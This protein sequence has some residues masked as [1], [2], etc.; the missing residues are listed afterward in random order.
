MNEYINKQISS[1][2][3]FFEPLIKP[4]TFMDLQLA[5]FSASFFLTLFKLFFKFFSFSISIYL[6]FLVLF[7]FFLLSLVF[8]I[9]DLINDIFCKFF[10]WFLPFPFYDD[11]P[12]FDDEEVPYKPIPNNWRE[13][14]FIY[15]VYFRLYLI[16][17]N[18]LFI[19]VYLFIILLLLF[20]FNLSVSIFT[21]LF[22]KITRF[23]LFLTDRNWSELR[24]SFSTQFHELE[25]PEVIIKPTYTT[26]MI[27]AIWTARGLADR[28]FF[29][30]WC[31][32]P[33]LNG[34]E[35][36]NTMLFSRV[37]DER[38]IVQFEQTYGYTAYG[39]LNM[40][41]VEERNYIKQLITVIISGAA[42]YYFINHIKILSS[43]YLKLHER[44]YIAYY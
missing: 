40:I 33:P 28:E 32:M 22:L 27:T 35:E 43:I 3:S 31:R 23:T 12:Y 10:K 2:R 30:K 13:Y 44:I 17:F 38:G 7:L 26:A 19:F 25:N 6:N 42:I 8:P 16:K 36:A 9:Y 24:R 39:N 5:L 37:F 14:L 1:F 34:I 4:F 21:S 20:N 15:V 29:L 41:E 11:N 18:I